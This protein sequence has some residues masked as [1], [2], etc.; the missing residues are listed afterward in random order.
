MVFTAAR[1]ESDS[2]ANHNPPKDH[3]LTI[4]MFLL[5]TVP[6]C[7]AH[8]LR[9]LQHLLAGSTEISDSNC[10]DSSPALINLFFPV[11]HLEEAS[12]ACR[13]HLTD[14]QRLA[15]MCAAESSPHTWSLVQ[16]L[17]APGPKLLG[18]VMGRPW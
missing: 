4:E 5:G 18:F 10:L 12:L 17:Q 15:R 14:Y 3:E 2:A 7:V 8:G 9:L 13:P 1:R 11:S 16:Y 6:D